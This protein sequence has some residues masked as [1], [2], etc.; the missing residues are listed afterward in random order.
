MKIRSHPGAP[1]NNTIRNNLSANY[2]T[3]L[4]TGCWIWIRSIDGRGYGS[5]WTGGRTTQAHRYYYEVF[6]GPIPD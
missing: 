3:D 2:N 4:V 1:W 6:T 5:I